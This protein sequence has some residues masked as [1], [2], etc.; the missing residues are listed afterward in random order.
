MKRQPEKQKT[1]E[2]SREENVELIPLASESGY[3]TT[4]DCHTPITPLDSPLTTREESKFT[5]VTEE[6][7]VTTE[8]ETNILND[9]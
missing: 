8:G 5:T 1:E 3:D 7:S 6:L 2:E 9:P 4:G